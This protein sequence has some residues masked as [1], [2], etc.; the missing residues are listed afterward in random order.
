MS[1]W[2][3][4]KQ[5]MKNNNK[6]KYNNKEYVINNNDLC[7]TYLGKPMVAMLTLKMLE[8]EQWI[9]L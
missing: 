1:N 7:N 5:H 6:C 8:S 2:E 4:A 9:L 3:Q